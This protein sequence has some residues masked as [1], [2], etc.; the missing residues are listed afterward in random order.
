LNFNL[1]GFLVSEIF[2]LLAKV[3]VSSSFFRRQQKTKR[4]QKEAFFGA[5]MASEKA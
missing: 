3:E 4:K 5:L 2:L 1:K